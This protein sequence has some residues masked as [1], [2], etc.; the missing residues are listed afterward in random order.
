M[1]Q[2]SI[3]IIYL[4]FSKF[5]LDLVLKDSN[6]C[7]YSKLNSGTFKQ[8]LETYPDTSTKQSKPNTEW[9]FIIIATFL[10]KHEESFSPER[11]NPVRSISASDIKSR[12]RMWR[13]VKQRG[14]LFSRRGVATR[15]ECGFFFSRR[16]RETKGLAWR[17][18]A[19]ALRRC[20]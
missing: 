8:R 7:R 16:E 15:A 13:T 17:W 11:A 2:N 12:L 1:Y 10:T 6:H 4:T 18:Q 20:A 5:L 9:C 19:T 3:Q 14:P